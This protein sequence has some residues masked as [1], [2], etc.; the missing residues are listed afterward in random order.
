MLQMEHLWAL[1]GVGA[2]TIY[3]IARGTTENPGI[4]TARGILEH[5]QAVRLAG[6]DAAIAAVDAAQK[7]RVV[8]LAKEARA[9][10]R[11]KKAA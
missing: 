10:K 4:T 11:T 8:R 7:A 3:K 1:S 5:V 2:R 9:A 6:R